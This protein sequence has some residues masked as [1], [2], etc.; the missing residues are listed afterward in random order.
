MPDWIRGGEIIDFK[1]I[2]LGEKLGSGGFGDVHV[3][4][5]KRNSQVAV[6]KLRVQR[7]SQ[8]KK[9]DFQVSINLVLL[10]LFSRFFT[11]ICFSTCR[12]K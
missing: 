6:K 3:G 7:V 1:D 5:W 8:Q 4:I 11:T 12:R 2:Q 9:E 10:L